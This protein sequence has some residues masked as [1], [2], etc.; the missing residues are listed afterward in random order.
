[1]ITTRLL[2]REVERKGQMDIIYLF[3]DKVSLGK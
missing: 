3:G 2:K 1:M